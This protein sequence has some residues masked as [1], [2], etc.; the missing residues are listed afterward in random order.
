MSASPSGLPSPSLLKTSTFI[1][2]WSPVADVQQRVLALPRRAARLA[3]HVRAADRPARPLEPRLRGGDGALVR[4]RGEGG[5]GGQGEGQ[6]R[7]QREDRL[8]ADQERQRAGK[9]AAR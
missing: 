4:R 9:M 7:E 2:P 3:G 5:G 8:H 1:H 6:E